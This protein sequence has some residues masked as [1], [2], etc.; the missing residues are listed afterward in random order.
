MSHDDLMRKIRHAQ[1]RAGEDAVVAHLVELGLAEPEPAPTH[2]CKVCGA[3]WAKGSEGHWAGSGPVFPGACC[4]GDGPAPLET[5]P[6]AAVVNWPAVTA[7]ITEYVAGYEMIGEDETGREGTYTPNEMER[8]LIIDAMN[9]LLAEPEF[10][11]LLKGG[12]A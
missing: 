4:R 7:A 12:A 11:A 1:V 8:G 9:G 5:L 3:L 2:R 6:A 10:L